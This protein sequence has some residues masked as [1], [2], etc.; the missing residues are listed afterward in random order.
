MTSTIGIVATFIILGSILLFNLIYT[1]I[2]WM[3]KFLSITITVYFSLITF[4]SLEDLKGWP[5]E[6]ILPKTFIVLAVNIN[7]PIS[8]NDKGGIYLW[9]KDLTQYGIEDNNFIFSILKPFYDFNKPINKPRSYE[10]K[11]N[12]KLHEKLSEVEDLIRQGKMIVGENKGKK[13]G[14]GEKEKNP[15]KMLGNDKGYDS[16]EFEYELK[17][18]ELPPA[19]LP[20]KITQ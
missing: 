19:K 17:F 8:Q 16:R 7:E 10:F 12:R 15:D 4:I 6:T 11:Y 5:I 13:D 3:V 20:E 18:Y 9:C 14:S 1:S 2:N